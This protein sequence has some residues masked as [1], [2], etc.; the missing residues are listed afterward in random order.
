VT[1]PTLMLVGPTAAGKTGVAHILAERHGLGLISADAMMVYRGMDIGTAKPTRAERERFDY[2]GLDLAEPDQSFSA[3]DYLREVSAQSTGNDR[4]VVGGT[5]LYV[6]ALLKGLDAAA[7]SDP[8]WREEAETC[9]RD[10]GFEVLQQRCRERCPTIDKDLPEGD[11][12]NPR[13]WIRWVERAGAEVATAPA[14]I[15]GEACS[16]IGLRRDKDDLQNR[17]IQRVD[18]MFALG[19]V[20]EVTALKNRFEHFS[21][22]AEKAIGYAEVSA[23]LQGEMSRDEARERMVIRTRQY[24]KRQMTWFR[25]QLDVHWIDAAPGDDD[26]ALASLVEKVWRTHG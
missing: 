12:G 2:S 14:L 13:R 20:D 6:R 4:A 17:I 10:E 22:T 11:R 23:M 25:H 26:E 19:L 24:A 8:A 18:A 21:M 7:G 3:H 15:P 1:L 5:G 16:V 9:L